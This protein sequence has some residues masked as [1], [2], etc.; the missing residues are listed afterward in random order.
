[1][2]EDAEGAGVVLSGA[3]RGCEGRGCEGRCYGY[4]GGLSND[5]GDL[6]RQWF[7]PLIHDKVQ[8]TVLAGNVT[9]A[10]TALVGVGMFR[11][12]HAEVIAAPPNLERQ[13]G[14]AMGVGP[15]GGGGGGGGGGEPGGGGALLAIR[16]GV[17]GELAGT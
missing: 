5:G 12:E 6:R 1:L 15:A 7:V 17:V 8:H 16:A 2:R 10:I 13:V 3:V 4:L 11:H 9:V 14:R